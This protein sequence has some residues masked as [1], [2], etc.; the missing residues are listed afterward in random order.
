MKIKCPM[1]EQ[2]GKYKIDGRK[3]MSPDKNNDDITYVCVHCG[4]TIYVVITVQ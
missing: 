3:V 1:C 2:I 4:K